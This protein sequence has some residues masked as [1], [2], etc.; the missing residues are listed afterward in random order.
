MP[1]LE[2]IEVAI[3][4]QSELTKLPE[5]PLSNS[6][7]Q[8]VLPFADQ[9]SCSSLAASSRLGS[10]P[11]Q[12]RNTSPRISVYIPSDP[13]LSLFEPKLPRSPV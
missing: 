12:L 6:S 10:L 3:V 2:G 5:F 4:T 7:Y 9:L 8:G 1:S 11:R 13:G